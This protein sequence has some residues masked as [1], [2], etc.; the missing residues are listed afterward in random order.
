MSS[1]QASPF[2]K[3][4]LRSQMR[5]RAER[6]QSDSAARTSPFQVHWLDNI[7]PALHPEALAVEAAGEAPLH[8]AVGALNSSQAFALNLGLPF[9][10]GRREALD[11]FISSQLGRDVQVEGVSFEYYGTGDYLAELAGPRPVVTDDPKKREHWTQV[12]IV[13]HLTAASGLS[14][15]LL[16]EVKLTEGGFTQCGG[17]ASPRNRDRTPCESAEAFLNDPGRCYLKRPRHASRDRRYWT[18]FPRAHGTLRA[19]FPG[20]DLS[21][22]CPFAG[23]WQQPMRNHALALA[24]CQ[25]GDADF[26]GLALL[27]HDGNPDVV[28]PWDSYRAASADKEHIY[29]W[30]ASTFLPAL[31]AT[32]PLID[33]GIGQWLEQRYQL[34]LRLP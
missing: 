28:G 27:H 2:A 16:V 13:F 29:R 17:R 34:G 26:W 8:P 20:S 5:A 22:P 10:E 4:L 31:D 21:G 11:A 18:I 19:A 14:G 32:F 7:H 25:A 1:F 33:P 3:H 15:L 30:P 9:A 24:A 23:H 6:E 12:D